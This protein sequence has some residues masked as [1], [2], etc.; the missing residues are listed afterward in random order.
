[1]STWLG[2]LRGTACPRRSRAP[3]PT[4]TP[5]W[6]LRV[7]PL[8]LDRALLCSSCTGSMG[9]DRIGPMVCMQP[10]NCM[11]QRIGHAWGL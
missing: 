8:A 2:C 3:R 7:A 6:C 1:M 10:F 5:G 9:Q 11:V 4:G